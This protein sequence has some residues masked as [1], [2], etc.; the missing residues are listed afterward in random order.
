[1]K[2]GL[3]CIFS[4]AVLLSVSCAKKQNW[5]CSCGIVNSSTTTYTTSISNATKNNAVDLCN[6][7]GGQNFPSGSYDCNITSAP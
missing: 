1:M 3:I 4:L 6:K 5:K 7:A 2:K